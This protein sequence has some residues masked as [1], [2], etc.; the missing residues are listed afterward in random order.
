MDAI[1]PYLGPW[2][3]PAAIFGGG[4]GAAFIVQRF[5]KKQVNAAFAASVQPFLDAVERL[6]GLPD[7]V[8]SLELAVRSLEDSRSAQT[9]YFENASNQLDRMNT[10]LMETIRAQAATEKYVA[11]LASRIDA[12]EKSHPRYSE[13]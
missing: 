4:F 8:R 2:A 10:L 9:S 7:V 5:V 13:P 11:V 6:Q 12:H 3:G 1:L